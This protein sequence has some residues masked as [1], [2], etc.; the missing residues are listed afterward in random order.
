MKVKAP[1]TV[2]VSVSFQPETYRELE[3]LSDKRKLSIAWLIREAVEKQ[4]ESTEP[5]L[6]KQN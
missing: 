6:T 5:L 2:R 1:K 4:L 3:R